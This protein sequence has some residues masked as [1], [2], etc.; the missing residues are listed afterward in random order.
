MHTSR[1]LIGYGRTIPQADWPGGARIAVQIVL[2]YE[3]GGENCILHGDAASEAFLSEIVGAAPWPGMRHMNMES[4]YE[5]GARAG[6]WRLW[7]LFTERGVPVTV[8]GVATAL[9]RNPEVVA[10][11][12]EADWEIASHGLKWID[13]RDMPRAEEAAQMDAA[14]RLHEEV[15]GERPLG[16]Y[17]GRSSVNTL[18]LGLERGFAYLADSYADDLPYWLYGRAGTGLVVPYTLDANDMRFAT[19]QG[20]NTGEHFFTYLRDSFDALYAEGA[21]APKMMS[22]GLH[23]RLVGRPGRIAALAR[24]LDHVAAHDGVWLARRIDIAR[25]WTARH[26]AETLRPSTMSAAQFL[27]RF[28]DIFEDTPEIAL[29]AWQAGLTAREDSAEGL[30]AALVGALR[31]LPAEQQ[32]ALIRAHPELAGRLAQAGQL[33]Q[34]S[35]TEQG[36]AGLGALS[37]EELA[38]FERLNA[39]YRARFDLPFIMA[40]KGSSREA[41]LAAFEARLRND[42]EQEFQEALRQIERIAW[43]R[44]KDR[45]PSES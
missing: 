1:D 24:F 25:H 43:L 30:H 19:A 32:R 17:T 14:I 40:I 45:L 35:T 36:S 10:A 37:A 38:R 26:P 20:F 8:F 34:A 2:N 9:A 3:E 7:R 5:Y 21:A 31:G 41:I 16:W 23:C 18:E 39:A 13:Y 22:V 28:G 15:T 44:L 33:T 6:F 12:R 29:R 42:P 4:L 11:M 27:T